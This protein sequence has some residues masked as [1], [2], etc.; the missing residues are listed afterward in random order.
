LNSL[1]CIPAFNEE[2]QIGSLVKECLKYSDHVVVCDDGSS[3]NTSLE[4]ENA[5]AFVLRH[6]INKGKGAALKSLFNYAKNSTADVIV[7]IDG[8]GQFLP[9]EIP[10]LIK[11]ILEKKSDIVIGYRF[12][13]TNKIPKYRKFG[14]KVI[15][16]LA[17]TA[18]ELSFRDTQS[19]FR[20]YSKHAIDKIKFNSDGF[21]ADT[22]ILL[23]V[24]NTDL[25]IS[26][27]NVTV[28]YDTGGRTSTKNPISHFG[29]VISSL[30]EAIAVTHPLKY[31]GVS[32]LILTI[33]GLVFTIFVM[34]LFNDTRYFSIPWTL[35]SLGTTIIGLMLLLMSIL[36]FSVSKLNHS[37]N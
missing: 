12:D 17:N 9:K 26:E 15:D 19:G 10:A 18:S 29:I 23:S 8:D 6:S 22:E 25:K 16:K 11:P 31:L 27:I 33:L 24:S 30:I 14:N 7:T 4:A 20:S 1:T 2:K 13:D 37:Q 34:T 21:T 3:D 28:I 35:A 5:G 32:G 36:L